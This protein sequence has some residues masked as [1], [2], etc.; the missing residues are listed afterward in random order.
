MKLNIL[1][2]VLVYQL[3]SFLLLLFVFFFSAHLRVV[4]MHM[5][6]SCTDSNME[7]WRS[8]DDMMLLL[9]CLSMLVV[10]LPIHNMFLF[11]MLLLLYLFVVGKS[12]V[13]RLIH[14]CSRLSRTV[15][16]LR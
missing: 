15:A 3:L 1:V 7:T 8:Y 5:L 2:L 14:R 10:V 4:Y 12:K 6:K 9:F 11:N 13:Q 16:T